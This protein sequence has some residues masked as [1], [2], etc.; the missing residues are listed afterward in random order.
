MR[1]LASLE[2]MHVSPHLVKLRVCAGDVS[3]VTPSF[4]SVFVK[5][6][7][8]YPFLCFLNVN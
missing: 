3:I 2:G 1:D 8:L 6:T 4:S 5:S 7:Q